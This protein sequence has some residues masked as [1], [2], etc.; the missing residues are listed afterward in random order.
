MAMDGFT[1]GLIAQELHTT[2]AQARV[3]KITQPEPDEILLALRCQGENRMLL[4]SANAG[5]AR[6]QMTQKKRANPLEPPAFC[7]LLRKRIAGSRIRSITQYRGDRIIDIA[8]DAVNELGDPC[9]LVLSAECMG[10]HSNL[11]FYEKAQEGGGRI[12]DS[13]KRVPLDV[14]SVRQVLPGLPYERP[15]M[16]DKIE[17]GQLTAEALQARLSG[18]TGLFRKALAKAVTGLSDETCEEIAWQ[19]TGET[20]SLVETLCLTEV[21]KRV[22]RWVQAAADHIQPTLYRNSEGMPLTV[23]PFPYATREH[24][25]KETYATISEAMDV[26]YSQ[27]DDMARIQ[28]KATALRH[29]LKRNIERCEKKLAIRLQTM[30]DALNMEEYR[31]KGE[32]LTAA[33]GQIP[34]GARSISL[35]NWYDENCGQIEIALDESL[36]PARNAQRYFK[37]YQKMRNASRMAEEQAEETQEELAYLEGQIANLEKSTDESDLQEIRIELEGLG[38]VR[39]THNRR[40]KKALAAAKPLRFLSSSGTEILVGKNNVQ[41]EKLTFSAAPMELWLH[42]KDMPGSHVIIKSTQPDPQTIQEAAM[43]AAY[44][45]KG[46]ASS[47]VPVDIVQ[48]RYIKKPSGAKPGYVI[49]THNTTVYV[50]PTGE[51]IG[52]LLT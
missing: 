34:K 24:L 31:I 5:A 41:N 13:A 3:D 36:S 16:Q 50:T 49:F 12:L 30:Q 19:C 2:L 46:Q 21:C 29:L 47:N 32:L 42:A 28:Q 35:P 45:S 6:V 22:A 37:L 48:R 25:A 17:R 4:L 8:F 9:E 14:S 15:P 11:I 26:F 10:R 23:C 39:A 33:I 20:E 27:R 7:M 44:Y 52:R 43:L 40:E 51:L 38:Y 18:A 1:L